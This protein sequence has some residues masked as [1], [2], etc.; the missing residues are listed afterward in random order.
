MLRQKMIRLTPLLPVCT[1]DDILPQ[2]HIE[3]AGPP[4]CSAFQSMAAFRV[5]AWPFSVSPLLK[6][7]LPSNHPQPKA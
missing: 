4:A 3:T 1:L 7:V 6:P 2:A 5:Q